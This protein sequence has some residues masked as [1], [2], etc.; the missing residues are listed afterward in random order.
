MKKYYHELGKNPDT[1]RPVKL[2]RAFNAFRDMFHFYKGRVTDKNVKIALKSWPRHF[3]KAN[4][5]RAWKELKDD[6]FA[7]QKGKMW[8]WPMMLPEATEGTTYMNPPRPNLL[9]GDPELFEGE[10]MK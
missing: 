4:V 2:D 8:E 9:P 5:K 7:V 10:W 1:G 6:G 3:G